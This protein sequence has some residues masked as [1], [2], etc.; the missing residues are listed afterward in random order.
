MEPRYLFEFLLERTPDQVYFKDRAGRFVC[1]S[2]AVADFLQAGSAGEI[3]GKT[4]RDYWSAETAEA[5]ATDE[6]LVMETREPLVG[7][8]ERLVHPDGRITWDHSTKLPLLNSR[9]EVIGICGIN[10]DITALKEMEDALKEERDLLAATTA[11]LQMKN[12]LLQADLQLAR[13]IQEALLPHDLPHVAGGKSGLRFAHCYRPAAAVG[14]DFFGIYPFSATKAGV[15]V[16][17]VMGHGLR[18]ALITAIIRALLEELRPLMED[19]GRLL[20]A[21]NKRLRAVLKRVEDP[22]VSTAFYLVA[23]ID[24]RQAAF[25]S[26]GHPEPLRLRG[27]GGAAEFLGGH[28]SP[29]GPALGLFEPASF[30]TFQAS[31]EPGDRLVLFTDGLF[32]VFSPSGMEFGRKEL[33]AVLGRNAAMD[34]PALF[35]ATLAELTAFSGKAEFDDD[36]C[37]VTVEYARP[38]KV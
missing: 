6:R 15:L 27:T 23:D 1:V 5:A 14:G 37:I 36:V 19:P 9:G 22:F 4:D 26:A 18:A 7:K 2:R 11:E 21:L 12:A 8:V 3:V 38:T 34:S 13:E 10:K 17:D 16:C 33:A 20:E 35:E 31:F 25:A 28:G 24:A 30:P 29:G 32:E